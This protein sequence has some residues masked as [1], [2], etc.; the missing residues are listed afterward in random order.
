MIDQASYEAHRLQLLPGARL[1]LYSD[2]ITE[3]VDAAG[4]EFGQPRLESLL[5]RQQGLPLATAGAELRQALLD[6]KGPAE[7][8]TDDVTFLALEYR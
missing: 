7:A 3:C 5:G 1:F 6:W 2:G 8:F 4:R